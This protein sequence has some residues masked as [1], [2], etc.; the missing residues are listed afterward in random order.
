MPLTNKYQCQGFT[1]IEIL[2]AALVLGIGILGLTTAMLLGLKSNQTAY[3]RSQASAAAYDMADR[4]RLNRAAALSGEYDD[5]DIDSDSNVVEPLACTASATGC[6]PTQQA[7]EDIRLWSQFFVAGNDNAARLPEGRG[8]V[9]RDAAQR[10]VITI[11]W[12]GENW[13]EDNPSQKINTTETL[14]ITFSL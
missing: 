5:I 11:N 9:S 8:R 1:L 14:S 13:D 4:I 6:T 12:S 3:F 2:V 10:Y 7:Q